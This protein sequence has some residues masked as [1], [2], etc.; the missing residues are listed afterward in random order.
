MRDNG[1]SVTTSTDYEN[2]FDMLAVGRFDAFPRGLNEADREM[3]ERK[4]IY[5]QL[6]VEKTKA[7]FFPFP[8]YFWVRNENVQLSRRIEKGLK[9]ALADGSFKKLFVTYHASEIAALREHS[10]HVIRLSNPTLPEGTSPV[11][12]SWWW[13]NAQQH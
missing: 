13:P 8:I 1:F 3:S 5:P 7:I 10:R 6:A 9:L 4:S 11:D 12:T 2:L